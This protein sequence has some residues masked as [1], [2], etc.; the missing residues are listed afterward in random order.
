VT[1]KPLGRVLFHLRSFC[2]RKSA[3]IPETVFCSCRSHLF[4]DNLETILLFR[5]VLNVF[6]ELLMISQLF[7]IFILSKF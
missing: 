7:Y 5:S 3:R 1:C 4:K 2:L 6:K